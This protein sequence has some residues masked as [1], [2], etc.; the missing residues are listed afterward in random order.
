MTVVDNLSLSLSS[1]I[2]HRQKARV[3]APSARTAVTSLQSLS[4]SLS[5][6]PRQNCDFPT[7][8]LK[9]LTFRPEVGW[10]LIDS[11]RWK[12][13]RCKT[14]EF[15]EKIQGGGFGDILITN[16]YLCSFILRLYLNMTKPS[17]YLVCL[18]IIMIII[19]PQ[20]LSVT[21]QVSI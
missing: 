3:E 7:I 19:W 20:H 15:S 6:S 18:F 21:I 5:L 11:Y 1:T 8:L 13:V 12:S 14:D 2:A 4:L 10:C 16:S 9:I 17:N